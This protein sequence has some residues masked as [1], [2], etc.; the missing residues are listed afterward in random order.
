MNRLRKF[1]LGVNY[2]KVLVIAKF[3]QRLSVIFRV[4]AR[5][6]ASISI[7]IAIILAV[8]FGRWDITHIERLTD[9]VATAIATYVGVKDKIS[10]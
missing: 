6:L 2:R 9:K 1:T 5:N 10:S 3:G 4:I 7:S 8:L